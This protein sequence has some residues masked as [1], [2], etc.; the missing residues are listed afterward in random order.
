V[1]DTEHGHLDYKEV[2]E[3][4]RALRGS[5]TIGLVRIQEIEQGVIKR[6]LDLGADGI[7]IPQIRTA[8]EVE[9]AVSFAKYPPR[10]IRGIGGERATAWGKNLAFAT[11][12]NE[13]TLVIP[14][15]ERV[16]AGHNIDAIMDV[17]GVDAF[18]FGPA[19]YS[20]SAGYPGEW[21]GPG[22]A[23]EILRVKEKILGRGYACGIMATDLANGQR[24][25]QQGFRLIGLAADAG[26]IIRGITEMLQGL[27]KPLNPEVWKD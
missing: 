2:L 4:L 26:L 6:V 13:H 18:F 8:E 15:I 16:E 19:D 9:L 24:R 14:L 22:V 5:E 17:P 10:G 11:T 3:H 12:G 23:E 7:I 1:I 27:G 21:E 20:A 25:V